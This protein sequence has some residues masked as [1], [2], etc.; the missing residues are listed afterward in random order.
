MVCLVSRPVRLELCEAWVCS[1]CHYVTA[2]GPK[3][4]VISRVGG[5]LEG[6]RRKQKS[7]ILHYP[8]INLEGPLEHFKHRF[9]VF[10]VTV[11]F[12]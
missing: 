3:V 6:E 10:E 12:S 9:H 2:K 5:Q 4:T 1:T 11:G 8:E 7:L